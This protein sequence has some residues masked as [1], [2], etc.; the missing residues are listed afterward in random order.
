MGNVKAVTLVILGAL[1]MYIIMTG[2]T[3]QKRIT[4]LEITIGQIVKVL[5]NAKKSE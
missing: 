4:S 3:I 1:V 5:N 2:F